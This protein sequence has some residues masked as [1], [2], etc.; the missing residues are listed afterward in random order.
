MPQKHA[1][2][3]ENGITS[4]HNEPENSIITS[5]ARKDVILPAS[6]LS[7]ES[8]RDNSSMTSGGADEVGCS[9]IVKNGRGSRI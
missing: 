7:V 5:F 9:P 3:T 1:T 4:L 6:D 8:N 2:K